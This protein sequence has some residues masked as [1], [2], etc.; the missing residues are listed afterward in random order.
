MSSIRRTSSTRLGC[1]PERVTRYVSEPHGPMRGTSGTFAY[2]DVACRGVFCTRG[3]VLSGLLGLVGE[4]PEIR[5]YT[6]AGRDLSPMSQREGID[7][8]RERV[9]ILE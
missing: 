5:L 7:G 2:L 1:Y 6:Y 8:R 9:R 3:P 4:D